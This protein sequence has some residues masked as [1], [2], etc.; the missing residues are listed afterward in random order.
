MK[1][2]SISLLDT[3]EPKWFQTSPQKSSWA[4]WLIQANHYGQIIQLEPKQRVDA[5]RGDFFI[6][7]KGC[8]VTSGI[9]PDGHKPVFVDAL[10]RGDLIWPLKQKHVLFEYETRTPTFLMKIARDKYRD[11]MSGNSYYETVLMA[12]EL[13]LMTKHSHAAQFHFAKDLDRIKRVISL[14]VHH[15]DSQATQRGI[16]VQASKEEIRYLAGVERRSGSRAFKV[17]E[18]EGVLSFS[19]YK[20]FLFKAQLQQVDA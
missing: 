3:P 20:S 19:G 16:E 1:N 4:S 10:R 14:L 7:L 12:G 18:D 13:D 9:F 15:P 6:V 11:F 5:N 2:P 8:V 17:L